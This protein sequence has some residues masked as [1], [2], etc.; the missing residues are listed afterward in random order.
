M[1][2]GR[3]ARGGGERPSSTV[4]GQR[5]PRW[6]TFFTLL[7]LLAAARLFFSSATDLRRV[8]S[9]KPEVLNFEGK[10]DAQQEGL[11]RGQMVLAH[12]LDVH[13]PAPVVV[14]A[15]ARMLLGLLFLLAVAAVFSGDLRAR[16]VAV[17]AAWGSLAVGLGNAAFLLF[18]VHKSLPW[19]TPDLS[20]AFSQLATQSGK[21]AL[22]LG[23]VAEQAQVFLFDVP[24]VVTGLGL[25]FSLLLLAYWNGTRARLFYN[26]GRRT[27]HG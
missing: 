5:R 19:L 18:V 7:M 9:G 2:G 1:N 20:E 3:D 17:W 13:H 8:A 10:L 4:G 11:L 27:D 21:P 12:A 26:Q 24:M 22:P 15:V 25:V 23:S 14:Q 6:M 16:Q